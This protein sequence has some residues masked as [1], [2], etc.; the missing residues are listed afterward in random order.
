MSAHLTKGVFSLILLGS[1][2][3]V[4]TPTLAAD[5]DVDSPAGPQLP[6]ARTDR[7]DFQQDEGP[8]QLLDPQAEGADPTPHLVNP[9][10]PIEVEP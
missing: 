1:V 8:G 3:L 5:P 10:P 7:P 6:T 9:L 4:G 2:A